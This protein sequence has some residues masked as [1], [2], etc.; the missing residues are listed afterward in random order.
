MARMLAFKM[1]SVSI[2]RTEAAPTPKATARSRMRTQSFSRSLRVSRFESSTPRRA[3]TPGGM[4][5]AD[6]TTGPA[7]EPRP[8]SS[9]PAISS[10]PDRRSSR[11]IPLQR[12]YRGSRRPPVTSLLL[13]GVLRA[14]LLRANARCLATQLAEVIQLRAPDLS[15]PHDRDVADHGAVHGEDALDADA[16]RDLADGEGLADTAAAPGNA[17]ALE[18]LKAL[19]LTFLDPHVDSQRVAGTERSEE[20]RV[21]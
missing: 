15:A 4:M 3:G 6:A 21:G 1:F 13:G 12:A 5:T 17:D 11:S 20:R 2:S 16:V 14:R 10:T 19:F 18:C 9:T 7:R 8:T